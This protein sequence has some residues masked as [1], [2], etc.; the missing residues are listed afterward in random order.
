MLNQEIEGNDLQRVLVGGLKDDRTG[1]SGLL[2]LQPARGTDAP[3]VA[4]LE[5]RKAIL[6]ER[7]GKIVAERLGGGE[8][9]RIDNAANGVDA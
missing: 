9:R 4:G 1:R 2:H 8:E 6:R 5:P 3:A 7:R